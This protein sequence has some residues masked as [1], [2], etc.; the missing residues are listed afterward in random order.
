MERLGPGMSEKAQA[1]LAGSKGQHLSFASAGPRVLLFPRQGM[2]QPLPSKALTK[3]RPLP[4]QE[5]DQ[6]STRTRKSITEQC[7]PS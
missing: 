1:A 7:H 5:A 6:R 2:G 3:V 4:S